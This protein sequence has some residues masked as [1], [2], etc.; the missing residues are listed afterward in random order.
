MSLR[1]TLAPATLPV[2]GGAV[3]V[4]DKTQLRAGEFSWAQNV[5]N[6]HPGMI[7]RKGQTKLHTTADG[8][9]DVINLYQ[10]RSIRGAEQKI[11]AQMSDGD[12][13]AQDT[14]KLKIPDQ[15]NG[16]PFEAA[17]A[18]SGSS[19]Q[20]PAS[21]TNVR[22]HMIY[23]N[24]A[25]QHQVYC[26]AGSL[27]DRFVVYDG[28]VAP[29]DIPDI[30]KDYSDEIRNLNIRVAILDSLNTYA[31]FECV[32]I[33]TKVPANSLTFDI[34][35][36]NGTASVLS[37]Y[38][39]NG[40]SWADTSATDG[41]T[42]GGATFAIDG[43]ITWT[44]PGSAEQEKFMYGQNGFWYQIRVS[45]QLD[46]EVEITSVLFDDNDFSDLRNI[47]DG[48]R[49]AGIEVQVYLDTDTTYS[50]YGAG[51]IDIGG[52]G[53]SD[54]IYVATAD[55][56]EAFYIESGDTP[57]AV[58]AT[59]SIF[60]W[61][62]TAWTACSGVS[63]GTG[64]LFRPG[65]ITFDRT[66]DEHPREFNTS[67]YHAYWY[68]ITVNATL[69]ATMVASIS[70][71]PY[72]NIQDF[73][74]VGRTC[75]TWKD[76]ACYS[77]DQYGNYIYVA[78]SDQ[79][80]MLNGVDYGILKAGDGRYN[81]VTA[82]RKFVNELMVW[83]E[84][85]GSEGGCV[86]IFEGY[87]PVT[88]G[89]LVLSSK[90]GCMNAKSVVVVDGV[91][92]STETDA[93]L[94]TLAFFLSRYGVCV[95][96]GRTIAISSDDI[97]NYFDT[98]KSEC[99]RAGQEQKMWLN[100]DAAENVIRVGLVISTPRST[101]TTTSTTANKLVDSGAAFTTDKTA[102]GDT[103]YNT[104][105]ETTALVTAIDSV[106]TLSLD[107]DIMVSGDNY[108]VLASTPNLFPVL[109]L[110]DKTW[111]F[112]EPGQILGCMAEVSSDSGAITQKP[113][114]QL[115]GGIDDGT[116]Y[117]LND[118]SDDV[119]TAIDSYIDIE[120][121]A[122][123]QYFILDEMAIRVK[124]QA[125]GDLTLTLYKNNVQVGTKTLDMTAAVTG[126]SNRRHRFY[127]N[128]KGDTVTLRFQNNVV[129]QSFSLHDLGVGLE[130]WEGM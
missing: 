27:I 65:W 128:I 19:G 127:L 36:P 72:F 47:W 62:G 69:S 25:D 91:M 81:K 111:S 17:A 5:R 76:R 41:T 125:A 95:T 58:A 35:K 8:T 32:F 107:S 1:R 120:I 14:S 100:H 94:K 130:I 51:A 75:C 82:Q 106:S 122:D 90:I 57:N 102:I 101:G 109:D 2:R 53:A 7:S 126:D 67:E 59:I 24:G 31:A 85:I 15:Y 55:K 83:Q 117:R 99:I 64:G 88:F 89:R 118:G 63:D 20:I 73:G 46:S 10:Y 80:L 79:P 112:D 129:S 114:I 61:N 68:K 78:K 124:T 34:F 86:T 49:I 3:T 71:M 38:Y 121:S 11:F 93:R 96:D 87:S 21:F 22:D 56:A 30:G 113:V 77:F 16:D 23:S 18:H 92:T 44:S 6:D 116:I 66:T 43:A 123:G 12:L 50:V 52:I 9:N 103:I 105:D 84:E 97:Q 28:T 119:S 54:A 42:S 13:R 110:V 39:W 104:D 33:K 37:L 26:G 98:T 4:R 48:N 29:A 40:S 115:G 60:Y 70:S 45:V 74:T 108:Q